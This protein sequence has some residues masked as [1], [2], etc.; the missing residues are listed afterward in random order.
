MNWLHF[1]GRSYYT[2]EKFADE[3]LRLGVNRR[4]S[5]QILSAFSWGD[6]VFLAFGDFKTK[7]RKTELK[8]SLVIGYF[9]IMGLGGLPLEA[10]QDFQDEFG[11]TLVR[12]G[13]GL[14]Q[15]ECGE[16]ESIGILVLPKGVSIGKV[17]ESFRDG[18]KDSARALSL[19]GVFV[20]LVPSIEIEPT[21]RFGYTKI[22]GA[23]TPELVDHLKIDQLPTDSQSEIVRN[24]ALNDL[25]GSGKTAW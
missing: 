7:K 24:Y 22:D 5:L 17:A 8:K 9:D 3:A 10:A 20:P 14:I 16:Y 6:R 25:W 21:F 13:E 4:V 11:G 1:L 12:E 2:P 19:R 18:W 15:R 23:L